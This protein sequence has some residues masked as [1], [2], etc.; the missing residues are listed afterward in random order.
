MGQDIGAQVA[1]GF[2]LGENLTDKGKLSNI[3]KEYKGDVQ[4][5]FES[6][7]GIPPYG[8]PARPNS[9]ERQ[10]LI[11]TMP[12]RIIRH[13]VGDYPMW[14]IAIPGT[15][16]RAEIGNPTRVFPLSL[17]ISEYENTR[18]LQWCEEHGV[19]VPENVGWYI[20]ADCF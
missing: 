6:L 5:F 15:V 7:L 1:Y 20:F 9:T 12:V 13:C 16:Q 14:F 2:N 8:D 4:L 3:V 17:F 18:F 19:G 10:R 11:G